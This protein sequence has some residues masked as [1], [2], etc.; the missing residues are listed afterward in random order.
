MPFPKKFTKG[1]KKAMK[2]KG[3][4]RPFLFAKKGESKRGALPITKNPYIKK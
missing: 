1:E 3:K 4:K 2:K